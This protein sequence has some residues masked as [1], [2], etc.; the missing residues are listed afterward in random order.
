MRNADTPAPLDSEDPLSATRV[1]WDPDG[2][3][4]LSAQDAI[5][6]ARANFGDGSGADGLPA[7]AIALHPQRRRWMIVDPGATRIDIPC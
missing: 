3:L 4:F 7:W 5:D 2:A 1:L 6:A